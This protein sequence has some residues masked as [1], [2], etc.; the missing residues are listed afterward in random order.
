MTSGWTARRFALALGTIAAVGFALRA[1]PLWQSPLPFNP[2]GLYHARNA[3]HAVATGRLPLELVAID[4]LGFGTLLALAALLTGERTLYIAQP[5]VAVVGTL[6]AVFG[7]LLA[8]RTSRRLGHGPSRMS[9]AGLV[10]GAFLAVGGVYLYRSMPVDEQTVGLGLVPLSLG[11]A[12]AYVWSGDRRWLVIAGPPLAILPS[13]H[14]LDSTV[15]GLSLVAVVALAVVRRPGRRSISG[16]SS[17]R[18]RTVRAL[19]I[20]T[21]YWLWFTTYMVAAPRFTPASVIQSQRVTAAPGLLVAWVVVGIAVVILFARLRTRAQRVALFAPFLCLFL[22]VAVNAVVPVFPGTSRTTPGVFGPVSG[23]IVP[24]VVAIWGAPLV[25]GDDGNRAVFVALFTGPLTFVGF[26]LSASLAPVY[27]ETA[28]RTHW[29]LYVPVAAL[30]GTAVA[31]LFE[32]QLQRRRTLRVGLVVLL[33]AAVAISVPTAFGGLAVHNYKGVTTTGEFAAS[34]F[35]VDHATTTWA[36]D[37]HL[38][39]ITRYRT[40][41]TTGTVGPVYDWAHET[42]AGPPDC[43]VLVDSSWTTVG[44]QFF[45][46]APRSVTT[47][48]L[49]AFERGSNTV[50]AGGSVDRIA[51]LVPQNGTGGGC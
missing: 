47:E 12:V 50:Y 9:V 15:V 4:D 41:G 39:R 18:G 24:V 29:F 10:A 16:R 46:R 49:A 36:S 1:L 25:L 14:N 48:R 35:A 28:I 33:I 23:L 17:G 40:T 22:L 6:P 19:G 34:T 37:D 11:A 44:A 42:D 5:F 13:I 3:G 51:L 20:A 43:P 7:A 21:A 2:D 26:A 38:V 31:I 45:P 30:T 8:R 32:G 27:L